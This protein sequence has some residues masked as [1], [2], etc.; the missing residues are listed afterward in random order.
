M[1]IKKG[2]HQFA[3]N[4]QTTGTAAVQLGGH[5]Q[6]DAIGRPRSSERPVSFSSY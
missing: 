2:I 3:S 6:H 4:R 5:P 1:R